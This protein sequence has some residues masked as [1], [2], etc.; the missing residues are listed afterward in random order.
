MGGMFI[1]FP[2]SH[3]VQGII[4]LILTLPVLFYSGWFLMKRGWVSFKTWNLNMFSL[5]ALGVAAA[6]IFSIIALLFPDIIPHQIR[7]EHHETPLYFE[8]VCVILTLVILGQL[9]EA[10]AHRKT[11]NAIRELMN[12]SPDE[13]NVI[14]N[15]EEKKYCFHRLK[16]V[17]FSK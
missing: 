14:I 6:F 13:A 3:E 9:M 1:N 8:A 2:F 11:G 17:T 16:S 5:I 12:L 4:E 7:G 10:A 15:G